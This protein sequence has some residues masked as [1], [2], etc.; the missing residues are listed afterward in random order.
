MN[1]RLVFGFAALAAAALSTTFACSSDDSGGGGGG[2]NADAGVDAPV[3]ARP[4]GSPCSC[5]AECSGDPQF[6]AVCLHGLCA[7]RAPGPCAAPGEEAGCPAGSKCFDVASAGASVCLPALDPANCSGGAINRH[8]VCSPIKGKGCDAS[9]G[10]GCTLTDPAPGTPGAACTADGQCAL[11]DPMCYD[12]TEPSGWEGGYCLSFG[13]TDSSQCNGGACLPVS[14]SGDGVCVQQCGHD[15]DCRVGY[16]CSK[17]KDGTGTYCRAGC[18]AASPCPSGRVCLDNEC[19]DEKV[20]CSASNPHGFCPD[21]SWCDKGTCNTEPFKCDGSKD[22]LEDNDSLTA[23]KPA[24]PGQT[25][26]LTICAGDE[27]WFKVTVPKGKIVRVGITFQHGAGDL[28]MIVLDN[29][30]YLIGSRYGE[31]Y[32]YG[33]RAQETNT[34]FY[35]LYSEAGGA[36]YM[37][38]VVGFQAAQNVYSLTVEEIDYQDGAVC[39]DIYPAAE[40][41]G[42]QPGGKGLIPLPFPDTAAV[43]TAPAN[44]YAWDTYSNYRFA[45]R[46]LAMLVRHA[47]A[48][49]SKA[50]P[51]TKP[52]GLIDT[53]QIDGI[54][55]GYDVNDP[56]HP[57]TTHDQGGNIDLAFY[58]TTP[59]NRARIVC[60]DGAKHADGFC[61]PNA[62]NTHTVDLPRQAFFMAKLFASPRLR[63]IGVD[64]VLAPLI[65]DAAKVLAALPPTDPH[66]IT[67]QELAKFSSAMAFGSGWPF[68]HHHIH[69][70]LHWWGS[71][72]AP[73]I[74]PGTI[75][76][77]IEANTPA[78]PLDDLFVAW[79]PR[80]AAARLPSARRLLPAQ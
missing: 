35:G 9:C 3:T 53:C 14:T 2:S 27:D 49:T 30:G 69:V 26:G 52:L 48:E 28:D 29:K 32:P 44:N 71:Q 20:A 5:D 68:H 50:F 80:G 72:T 62:V 16:T 54:T 63:V 18:D 15:L 51:G 40:C 23:A 1:T 8:E 22:A 58:Q 37:L 74:K 75:S 12:G 13:C 24:P 55:P 43:A 57:E 66:H 25:D 67:P 70:S 76:P 11:T 33:D 10:Q 4:V 56:R 34:E 47:I 7:Q 36:E 17:V 60:N 38:R 6:P 21:G 64:Q 77:F 59:D 42:Q 79:P 31:I 41:I 39:S 78:H 46:E 65:G 61:T 73:V 45:R 19:I